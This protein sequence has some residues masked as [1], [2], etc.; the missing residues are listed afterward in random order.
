QQTACDE[1]LGLCSNLVGLCSTNTPCPGG[2]QCLPLGTTGCLD[3]ASCDVQTYATPAV[4]ISNAPERAAAIIASLQGVVPQ[5]ETPTGP[6]LSG[7]LQHAQQWAIDHPGRQVVAV[8]ATDGFPTVCA[9]D[10]IADLAGLSAAAAQAERPVKTFVVGVFSNDDLG[11]DGQARLDELAR[12]GGTERAFVV[13]TGGDVSLEFLQAL[14]AIRSSVV[15]CTFG[16]QADDALDFDKVNLK[17][18]A[19]DGSESQ[20][21]NA[22]DAAGCERD[23]NGWYYVRDERGTPTQLEVCPAVCST[24]QLGQARVDLQIGCATIIR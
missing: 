23:G 22:A 15:G 3:S 21:I 18:T 16:L 8:L 17:L 6:A 14:E 20:L 13:E 19:A 1:E 9:P 10:Q 12:A 2:A 11:Q 5:G 7:A 24:L 4:G